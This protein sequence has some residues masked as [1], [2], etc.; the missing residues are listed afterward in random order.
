MDDVLGRLVDCLIGQGVHGLVP[1][2]S[3]GEFVCL[4][5]EQRKRVVEVVLEA[6]RGRV[7]VVPGAAA[8]ATTETA[9]QAKE[10]EAM[11]AV[12]HADANGL[13]QAIQPACATKICTSWEPAR[14]PALEC[15]LPWSPA[16]WWSSELEKSFMDRHRRKKE[17]YEI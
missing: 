1:L 5:W 3:S 8:T 16:V 4:N 2:G 12:S 7:P 11:G 17:F 9:R 15:P 10:F 14:I 13:L 6:N